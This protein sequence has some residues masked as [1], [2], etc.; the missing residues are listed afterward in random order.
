MSDIFT[1][2]FWEAAAERALKTAAQAA[3]LT[4]GADRID[5]LHADWLDVA[6]MALGGAVL[7][8]LTSIVS[9]GVGSSGPSL[10]SAESLSAD[11]DGDGL[12]GDGE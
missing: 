6:G 2:T 10:T 9:A 3:L 4:L 8:V 7:S 11:G 5:A 12:D 1:I